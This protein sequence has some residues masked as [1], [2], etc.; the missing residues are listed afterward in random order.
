MEKTDKEKAIE[1]FME[2]NDC[3][4]MDR[5]EQKEFFEKHYAMY[6][7]EQGAEIDT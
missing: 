7:N 2:G 5:D 3:Q 6:F 1:W 4:N